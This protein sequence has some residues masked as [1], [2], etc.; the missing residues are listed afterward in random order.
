MQYR[1]W[2]AKRVTTDRNRPRV[3]LSRRQEVGWEKYGCRVSE[4]S[5]GNPSAKT[6]RPA[7]S[8]T[9]LAAVEDRTL[10]RLS[11]SSKR[12]VVWLQEIAD[13]RFQAAKNAPHDNLEKKLATPLLPL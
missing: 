11:P 10:T 3:R 7:N 1:A 13:F 8:R 4:D 5:S 2:A 6:P 12:P 9:Y